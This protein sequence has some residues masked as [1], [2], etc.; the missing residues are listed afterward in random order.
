MADGAEYS[1]ASALHA[2]FLDD[3]YE[4]ISGTCFLSCNPG[5]L[6]LL[7]RQAPSR[8]QRR[9][10]DD[11]LSRRLARHRICQI[12]RRTR[13]QIPP[14]HIVFRFRRPGTIKRAV[15]FCPIAST[16]LIRAVIDG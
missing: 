5:Y 15:A 2:S 3:L 1:L 10:T 14:V 8:L 7:H 16:I 9:T 11:L 6:F 13:L 4:L 12:K